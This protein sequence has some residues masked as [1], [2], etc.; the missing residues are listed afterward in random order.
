[1]SLIRLDDISLQFGEQVILRE[2]AMQIESGER[3]CLIGR[4]GAGK[5]TLL[6]IITGE[7]EVDAGD[8]TLRSDL[9]ISKLRQELP[10]GLHLTVREIVA[11]GLVHVQKLVDEYTQR[12]TAEPDATELRE[13]EKLQQQI[14][15]R[16]GWNVD[17]QVDRI[18]T[19]LDLPAEKKLGDLS[20]GWRR[21]VA[22]AR[23]LVSQP[24]LLLLDE[25]TNHLDLAT[26]SWLEDRLYNWQ[27]AILF[28][29]HDRSFLQ[30]LA[31]RIIELDRTRL[32]SWDCDY[33]TYLRRR[34][35]AD[36]AESEANQRFDKKLAEEESWVRQGIK[37]RRTRNEGRVRALEAMREEHGARVKREPGARIAIDEAD[38]SGRKVVRMRNVSYSYGDNAI[39]DGLTLTIQRGERIGLVGNNGVGKSTLLRLLLGELAPQEGTVKI[40]TG[41]ET[42]YFDQLR[43]ELDPQRSVADIVGDGRDYITINGKQRHV[44]G[45]LRGF[46]FSA[47]RAMS[48][49]G[50]L[51]GGERNRVLLARLF[52]RSS[53]LLVLDEPTNDLDVETLEVLEQ[54]LVDYT[55][56]LIVVSHDRMFLD[57]VATSI[58]VFEDDGKV[59]RYPGG[60]SDWLRYGRR[61]ADME[62]PEKAA[63]KDARAAERDRRKQDAQKLSYK[64]Q[65][66]LD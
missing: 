37:A 48:P 61:L 41:L 54:K 19:E 33:Q 1:M 35:Q 50:I 53:N 42:A 43:R 31:T 14:D 40:G 2:A 47:K 49:A 15:A 21:R 3:V 39:I 28:I 34:E 59:H 22:L 16:G 51:S 45:Y 65:R 25:P 55:G 32:I 6:K 20:G 18:I 24:D 62:D 56:T 8:I 29:T 36:H 5:T 46:L 4:N 58:L 26:I 27:G 23:A 38:E 9:G 44:V 66:E 11:E 7:L 60:Y 12:S 13:L 57:N 63:R 52:T 30:R 17:Q 10:D 64:E